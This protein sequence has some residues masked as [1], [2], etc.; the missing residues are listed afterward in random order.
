MSNFEKIKSLTIEQMAKLNVRCVQYDMDFETYT[1][2]VT[3]DGSEFDTRELAEEY[4]LNWLNQE[5]DNL[6]FD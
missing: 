1:E 4:E 2:Y 6:V 5:V 3:S